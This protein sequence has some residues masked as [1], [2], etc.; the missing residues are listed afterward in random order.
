MPADAGDTKRF[1]VA[2]LR[3]VA[4]GVGPA[5]AAGPVSDPPSTSAGARIGRYVLERQLGR[6]GMADVCLATDP[7]GEHLREAL[8]DPRE[9]GSGVIGDV[10]VVVLNMLARAPGER[11]QTPSR[12][13]QA[14]D[15]VARR[16]KRR[17]DRQR[18]AARV[19]RPVGRL[20]RLVFGDSA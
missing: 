13:L 16:R 1:S 14:L 6:G 19:D 20:R 15:R 11:Y 3:A 8:P 4:S 9:A 10:A 18:V 5:A 17:S 12:L 2:E 7:G